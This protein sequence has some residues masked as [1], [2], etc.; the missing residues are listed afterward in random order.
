MP[1]DCPRGAAAGCF[2]HKKRDL[3]QRQ[4]R[5]IVDYFAYFTHFARLAYR[6]RNGFRG[7]TEKEADDFFKSY[8]WT[9]FG[10]TYSDLEK[11]MRSKGITSNRKI[12]RLFN[13]AKEFGIIY[14]N[15]K[16]KYQYNG[17]GKNIPNDQSED[18]PFD[19]PSDE[20]PF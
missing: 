3:F 20:V 7:R 4:L 12:E 9:A 10:T 13:T 1:R 18:L 8:K 14:K 16:G 5:L 2:F 17:L 11:Y 19:K 6:S 15:E